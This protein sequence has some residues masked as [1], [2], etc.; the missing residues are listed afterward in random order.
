MGDNGG[1]EVVGHYLVDNAAVEGEGLVV[2][3]DER[4][5]ALVR[6]GVDESVARS[7]QH[8]HKDLCAGNLAGSCVVNRHGQA[9]KVD[10]ELVPQGQ[11]SRSPA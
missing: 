2:A 4:F 7:A 5:R 8:G 1:L 11:A 3:F 9:A 6:H 10:E